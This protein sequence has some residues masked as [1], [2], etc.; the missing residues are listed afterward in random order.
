MSHRKT[1]VLTNYTVL[2]WIRVKT[3]TL[4]VLPKACD[5]L[6][7]CDMFVS[8]VHQLSKKEVVPKHV[9]TSWDRH[10]LYVQY[11][12]VLYVIV[13]HAQNL[14]SGTKYQNKQTKF[15][16]ASHPCSLLIL[17]PPFRC[18]LRIFLMMRSCS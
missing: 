13:V 15:K 14:L 18:S 2:P 6:L 5:N 10:Q 9:C 4:L 8:G 16:V 1:H 7:V 11:L 3:A 17:A 12:Q